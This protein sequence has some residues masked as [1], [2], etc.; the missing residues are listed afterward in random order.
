VAKKRARVERRRRER[1]LDK[2]GDARAKLARLTE[3]GAPERP[4]EVP[5]ASVIEAHAVGLGCA[6]CEG[7]VRVVDHD[8][9]KTEHGVLRRVQAQCKH[10][11]AV[12]EV[13]LR[14]VVHL[15]S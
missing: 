7:E 1:A 6:R 13:W 15:P 4:I 10:C 14:V 12:R 2:I 8:A 9:V 3:G 5:S 11:R